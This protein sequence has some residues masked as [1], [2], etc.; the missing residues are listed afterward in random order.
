M[1][2]NDE[3]TPEQ[4]LKGAL[5]FKYLKTGKIPKRKGLFK[6]LFFLA[7]ENKNFKGIMMT[8]SSVTLKRPLFDRTIQIK[9]NCKTNIENLKNVFSKYIGNFDFKIEPFNSHISFITI[10]YC[11]KDIN[12]AMIDEELRTN[13]KQNIEEVDGLPKIINYEKK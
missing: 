9:I 10:Y 8:S 6:I 5:I 4:K 13:Y 2:I 1:E 12:W 11:S 7:E 3:L